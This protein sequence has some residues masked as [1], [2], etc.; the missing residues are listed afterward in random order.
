MMHIKYWL[1]LKR[2]ETPFS[3]VDLFQTRVINEIGIVSK[4]THE[5]RIYGII[6]A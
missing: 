4:A 3:F 5:T 1:M 6:R 2:A